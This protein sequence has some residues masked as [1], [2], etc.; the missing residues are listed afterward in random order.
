MTLSTPYTMIE[1]SP[2]FPFLLYHTGYVK[3]CDRAWK[4]WIF[5]SFF[6][7]I[8]KTAENILIKKIG[9]NHGILVYKKS[10]NK[11]TSKKLYFSR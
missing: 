8:L 1:V 9:R 7:N 2:P 10:P 5:A 4:K 3:Y 6:R 11:W